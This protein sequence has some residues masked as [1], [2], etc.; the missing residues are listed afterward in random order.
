MEAE[1]GDFINLEVAFAYRARKSQSFKERTKDVHMFLAFWLPGKI[2]IPVWVDVKGIVGIVRLRLQLAPDPPFFQLMTLTFLGQPKVDIKCIP[3][4]KHGLNIMDLPLISNFV[5]SSVNAAMAEY[6]APKSLT[7]DLKDML[8][9]DDFKKD[10]AARGIIVVD[11]KRGYDFKM[12]DASIPMISDGSSD[13]YVS[14]G[15]AKFGKAIF[16]TR[17]MIS[18]MEPHWHERAVLLVTP[19]ELNVAERLRLQL[20]DSDRFTADDDLGRIEVDL[21]HIM[22]S[23]ETNGKMCGRTDGF[24]AL[25]AGENSKHTKEQKPACLMFAE[26]FTDLLP[27]CSSAGKA[28]LVGRLLL[29]SPLTA[30]PIRGAKLRQIHS[31]KR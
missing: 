24:R 18:E 4:V 26:T 13:P 30:L 23:D 1:E 31:I 3:I 17:V 28:R 9:G 20:W 29:Q 7:L 25:K 22:R 15:W 11:I 2:K 8:A 19:E 6:V 12:G 21:K 16:S 10:T 27:F 14:V 5:Q